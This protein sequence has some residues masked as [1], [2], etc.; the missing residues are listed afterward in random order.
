LAHPLLDK[1]WFGKQLGEVRCIFGDTPTGGVVVSALDSKTER[2]ITQTLDEL[3][4]AATT[5]TVA[6]RLVT[7]QN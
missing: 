5:I 2:A 7:V 6:Q 1:L 4:W 3:E